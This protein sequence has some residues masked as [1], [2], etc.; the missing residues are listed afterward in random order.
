[1]LEA[2]RWI[3]IK[4]ISTLLEQTFRAG[5][6]SQPEFCEFSSLATYGESYAHLA[7]LLDL[8]GTMPA[9][10]EEQFLALILDRPSQYPGTIGSN[11]Y[12]FLTAFA[13][14]RSPK[15]V[16]EIGTL[17]G[18]SAGII[19][20]ALARRH[21]RASGARVDTIDVS[22]N[23]AIDATRPTGFE[24][25]EAFS[26]MAS[27]VHVQAPHDSSFV[28]QLVDLDELDLAFVDAGHAH[29]QPLLDLLRLA[30]YVQPGGWIIFHDVKLGS[31][32]RDKCT[33]TKNL[34]WGAPFGAE[35]LFDF[36]PFRKI[37]GGNI[38]ALQLPADKKMLVGFALQLISLPTE[39]TGRNDK[40]TREAFFSSLAC[41]L[42][43][44]GDQKARCTWNAHPR[45]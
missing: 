34:Q 27:M 36:W 26:D 7:K 44:A 10:G 38:G 23:C 37:S 5:R 6:P 12:F 9:L 18:F 28:G 4:S 21:G 3:P 1:M 30:P 24:I 45:G 43:S 31:Q 19:A 33:A 22:V 14:I 32:G 25:A 41:I 8:P 11:D 39:L 29:P 2:V 20:A 13:S 16:I 40:A 42:S 17:T 15:R 35:W